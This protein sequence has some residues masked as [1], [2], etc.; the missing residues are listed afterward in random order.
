MTA[1]VPRLVLKNAALL[2]LAQVVGLPLTLLQSAMTARY[3]GPLALGYLYI[4]TTFNSF[5][6]MAVDWGQS[7]AL[8][9]LVATNRDGAGRLL[10]TALV[11][12]AL[13]AIAVS[14]V[15]FVMTYLLGYNRQVLVAVSL[16][17]VAVTFSELSNA[18]QFTILGFERTDF[19]ARRQVIEQL[20]SVVVVGSVLIL[21]GNLT[22]ILVAGPAITLVVLVYVSS[23]L[24]S[25]G[26]GRLSFDRDTLLR[27]LRRGTPFVFFSLAMAL[28]P[29]IDTIFISKLAPASVGWYAAARKL[30]GVLVF[31]AAVMMGAVY[32]TLC[33]LH[34]TDVDGFRAANN[35]ALR[36]MTLLAFPVAL[37]CA[38]FPEIGIAVFSRRS[39]APAQDDLRVLAPF[40]FLMYFSM[41]I[42]NCFLAANKERAWALVQF[43][44]V[45][46]SLVLDPILV[47]WFARRSGNGGLGVCWAAV[48]SEVMVVAVGTALSPRGIF[49][50][51]LGRSFLF[52]GLSGCAMVITA[53]G[54]SM[55]SPFVVA[56]IA[57]AAYGLTLWLTGGIEKS[58]IAAL[59]ELVDRKLA[60]QRAL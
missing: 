3:L 1:S 52:A 2:A 23:T 44:C 29:Y 9:A 32:P 8:P 34:A 57:L 20:L 53:R 26:I 24:R 37:G 19:T 58:Q 38:L 59:R 41:P 33:R 7:G 46:M 36:S 16:V 6:F 48:I 51:R 40:L 39:F 25:A 11:W 43:S 55:W 14:S 10:G 54:L 22:A 50:R 18:C 47:P 49:D 15:L 60:G 28:Q 4:A 13:S 35:G 5:G 31:P 27:I 42:G 56:P 30:L 45:V 21:G 12:R 17:S